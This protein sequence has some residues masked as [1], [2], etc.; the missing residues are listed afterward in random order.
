MGITYALLA[1]GSAFWH[2][3]QTRGVG[4]P[5]DTKLNDL[6]AFVAYQAAVENLGPRDNSIIHDLSPTPRWVSFLL[7]YSYLV[8]LIFMILHQHT[9]PEINL[10]LISQVN[11]LICTLKFQLKNGENYWILQIFQIFAVSTYKYTY[12]KKLS[13]TNLNLYFLCLNL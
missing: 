3:S 9:I 5:A 8:S 13:V 7:T 2:G 1:Q 12:I 4:L 11:L 6:F 10:L